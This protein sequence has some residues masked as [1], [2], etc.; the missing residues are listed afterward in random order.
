MVTVAGGEDVLLF[1]GAP[2]R[3]TVDVRHPHVLH[4]RRASRR[5]PPGVF[6]GELQLQ[7]TIGAYRGRESEERK[8]PP[9]R[10]DAECKR[11]TGMRREAIA[12]ERVRAQGA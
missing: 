11:S 10:S 12:C 4:A 1:F 7:D 5:Y 8:W 6:Q 2:A 3:L 9:P